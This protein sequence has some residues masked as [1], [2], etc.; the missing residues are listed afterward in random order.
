MHSQFRCVLRKCKS[1][2]IK[3]KTKF[4]KNNFEYQFDLTMFVLNADVKRGYF[5][6][7]ILFLVLFAYPEKDVNV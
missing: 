2:R 4:L 7:L 1:A 5:N 3:N 6:N